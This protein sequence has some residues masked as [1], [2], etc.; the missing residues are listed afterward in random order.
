M[1]T[2]NTAVL[3]AGALTFSATAHAITLGITPSA[4]MLTVGDSLSAEVVVS[5][6]GDFAP[7]SLSVFDLN[8]TFT[9]TTFGFTGVSFGSFLGDLGLGE[10]F[11]I[12]DTSI[13]GIVNLVEV[14]WLEADGTT[15]FFCIPPYLDD[16][17]PASFV[18]ATL[19]FDVLSPGPSDLTLSL[20]NN[21]PLGDGFGDPLPEVTIAAGP[22]ITVQSG[23]QIPEPATISLLAFGMA[24]LGFRGI[25]R[26]TQGNLNLC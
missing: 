7:P 26:G 15:C 16:I 21:T 9:P 12:E 10:A 23:S 6:L 25:S 8:I 20:N 11:S 17:Q 24:L 18:L 14:S 19:M 3:L 4:T 1:K 22:L 5:G 13:P 2:I